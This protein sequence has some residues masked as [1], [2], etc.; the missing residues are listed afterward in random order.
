MFLLAKFLNKKEFEPVLACGNNESL[1]NWCKDFENENI[2]VIRIPATSKHS[3]KHYTQLKKI[4]KAE[5]PD[6]IHAH[7]WNPASCRYA[8]M[9]AKHTKTPIITTEH[10]PFKLSAIKNTFKKSTLKTVDK[11]ITVS[12]ENAKVLKSLYPARAKK[13]KVIHNGI[14]TTWWRSQNLRFTDKDREGI[15]TKIF[16]AHADTLILICI[17]ELH[18]RKG[19]E[20]LIK[21]LP[22]LVAQYTNLKLVLVGEGPD[23]NRLTRL[24]RKLDLE[25]HVTF[26][27][28]QNNVAPL[29]KAS[30]IFVLPSVREAFGLV[31]A[32]AM[33]T[34]LPVVASR[35]GGIPELVEDGKT[36]VLVE[37]EDSEALRKA[38]LPLIENHKKRDRMAHFGEER[39]MKKF[40]V[41]VMSREYERIYKALTP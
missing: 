39:V 40:N 38:L 27:G 13:I 6:L 14:D 10:D 15:K 12:K 32:E 24:V 18:K 31:L 23:R 28:K 3:P 30:N 35:V 9:A 5:K 7:V 19:Q 36:G 33:I 26:T 1:N 11:I 4:I 25:H 22:S 41:K 21:A 29:L 34:P 2:N 8:F 17:A 16:H 37:P 20:Y